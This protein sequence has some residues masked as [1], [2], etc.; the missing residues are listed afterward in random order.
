MKTTRIVV[1]IALNL[2][3]A[4]CAR[5]QQRSR[6]PTEALLSWPI[7]E[8]RV[9]SDSWGFI[10]P[11]RACSNILPYPL[12]RRWYSVWLT[13]VRRANRF[14][15]DYRVAWIS[16]KRSSSFPSP[17]HVCEVDGRLGLQPSLP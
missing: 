15:M 11:S 14:A 6:L 17:I 5:L 12:G 10:P 1:G 13:P 7:S 8:L 2:P 16:A 4:L 3:S 9:G